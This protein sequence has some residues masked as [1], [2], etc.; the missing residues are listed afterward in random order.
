VVVLV[1]LVVVLV[2]WREGENGGR[3]SERV[4]VF[5]PTPPPLL[6]PP[7]GSQNSN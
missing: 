1:V 4:R 7:P 2:A 5:S 3:V 6:D